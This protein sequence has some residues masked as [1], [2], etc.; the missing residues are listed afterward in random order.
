MRTREPFR[1]SFTV[2]QDLHP[3]VTSFGG[4]WQGL[5]CLMPWHRESSMRLTGRELQRQRQK[6]RRNT[7]SQRKPEQQ[8]STPQMRS[9][10][11]TGIHHYS[12]VQ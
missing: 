1:P 11:R 4:R 10:Q 6:R 2:R 7:R 5:H 3:R 8:A 9:G 12:T